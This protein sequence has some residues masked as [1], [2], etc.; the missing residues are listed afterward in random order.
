MLHTSHC[1]FTFQNASQTRFLRGCLEL[2]HPQC[3]PNPLTVPPLHASCYLPPLPTP[4]PSYP[5]S[6][7]DE[8]E[9][10]TGSSPLSVKRGLKVL[11]ERV[12]ALF[13]D[14]LAWVEQEKEKHKM[15]KKMQK[16]LKND[17]SEYEVRHPHLPRT[18]WQRLRSAG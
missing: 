10:S 3:H 12:T 15:A 13:E 9:R 5:R 14:E 4:T 2:S 6:Y 8:L 17:E 16:A 11:W 18:S 7:Y 1:T